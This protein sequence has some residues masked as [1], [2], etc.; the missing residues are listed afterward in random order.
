MMSAR[1]LQRL[2][3]PVVLVAIVLAIAGV[4]SVQA[5][6]QPND[7]PKRLSDEEAVPG[8]VIVKFEEGATRAQ[9]SDV[10]RDEGLQ[11]KEDLDLIDAEVD[12]VRGQSVEQAIRDLER[13]PDVEYAE[14]DFVV[15]PNAFTDE[16][17][18]GLEWGL[19]NTGQ[20]IQDSAG[21]ADVDINGK[22]ASTLSQGDPTL[23]HVA[24]RMNR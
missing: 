20:T 5:Q 4:G 24:A 17:F 23:Q 2:F 19:D 9:V 10:R 3:W 22:E 21:T 13:R 6:E 1:R 7:P 15:H 8:Q 12:S 11:K 18:F 14:P 16:P